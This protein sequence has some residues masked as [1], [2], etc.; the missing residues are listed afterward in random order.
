[1]TTPRSHSDL[2]EA[3][4]R[5]LE[6]EEPEPEDLSIRYGHDVSKDSFGH[7]WRSPWFREGPSGERV[8][9]F[10][11]FLCDS[12][13]T[14][15]WP[16]DWPLGSPPFDFEP[17]PVWD[18]KT[19]CAQTQKVTQDLKMRKKRRQLELLEKFKR[20]HPEGYYWVKRRDRS[21]GTAALMYLDHETFSFSPF[22]DDV[23]QPY[24]DRIGV[25][26]Y[27]ILG[28]QEIPERVRKQLS[29]EIVMSS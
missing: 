17:K 3:M 25:W 13:H 22:P 1:M 14:R 21:D 24:N 19:S 26:S 6:V 27:H 18:G 16:S 23:R 12:V 5:P 20:E 4:R 28:R 11:C 9:V 8:A 2:D 29:V 15:P 10:H 7:C